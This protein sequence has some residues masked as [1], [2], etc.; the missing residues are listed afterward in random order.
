MSPSKYL[1]G[2]LEN[3][4]ILQ[5]RSHVDEDLLTNL[6]EKAMEWFTLSTQYSEWISSKHSTFLWLYG[7]PGAGKTVIAAWLQKQLSKPEQ[8]LKEQDVVTIFCSR[9][10]NE[11]NMILGLISQLLSRIDRIDFGQDETALPQFLTKF[12][13]EDELLLDLWGLLEV[14]IKMYPRREVIFIIDGIDEVKSKSRTQ[15]LRSLQLLPER[16]NEGIIV[17]I[18]VSSRD[19]PDIRDCL[20]SWPKIDK[21]TEWKGE[22]NR[23]CI[24]SRLTL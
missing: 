19:F 8:T 12:K 4:G 1:E 18:L 16:I 22:E 2:M 11:I 10:V 15:F 24:I 7:L 14:L 20:V 6:H 9:E 3:C 17:R 13:H 23:V 5:A 21:L